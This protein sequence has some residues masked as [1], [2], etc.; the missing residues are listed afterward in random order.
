MNHHDPIHASFS[1]TF[2]LGSQ[3]ALYATL[4][5]RVV[6]TPCGGV[7]YAGILERRFFLGLRETTEG[8]SGHSLT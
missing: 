8:S 7:V 6:L 1:W 4:E 3:A 5:C 2:H